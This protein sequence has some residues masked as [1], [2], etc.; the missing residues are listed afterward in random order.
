LVG[1]R[2][3]DVCRGEPD[4]EAIRRLKEAR[5][6]DIVIL[7]GKGHEGS[8]QVKNDKTMISTIVQ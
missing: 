1:I 8:T 5:E 3:T 6:G 2:R 4:R 7:A